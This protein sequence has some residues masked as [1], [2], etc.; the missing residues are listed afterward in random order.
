[1]P[2]RPYVERELILSPRLTSASPSARVFGSG[3]P[4]FGS[5]A[6]AARCSQLQGIAGRFCGSGRA[7][8]ERRPLGEVELVY[9]GGMSNACRGRCVGV[10][11]ARLLGSAIVAAKPSTEPNGPAGR[12]AN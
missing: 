11:G 9:D 1:M 3:P 2:A 12:I 4:C 6:F 5:T 10:V 7:E 8:V